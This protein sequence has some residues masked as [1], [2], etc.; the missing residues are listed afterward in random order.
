MVLLPLLLAA[1]GPDPSVRQ[2]PAPSAEEPSDWQLSLRLAV[3]GEW[4]TNARRALDEP[5]SDSP[6]DGLIRL[7]VDARARFDPAPGHTLGAGYLLGA[8]RFFDQESEDLLFHNL[9]LSSVHAFSP[10]WIA[11]VSA[12]GKRSRIRGGTR[13]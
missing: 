1:V 8:K 2:E 10:A 12:S 7:L 13:N 3:G 9:T 6:A 5:E 4:D 11:S